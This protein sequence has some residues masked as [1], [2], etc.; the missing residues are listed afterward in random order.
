[1]NLSKNFTLRE[2]SYSQSAERRGIDNTPPPEVVENLKALCLAVLQPLREATG[3]I[4]VTS[5]Y[6]A[7]AL[8]KV[9]GGNAKGQHPLGQAADCECFAMSTRALAEKVIELKL[10]FDQLI[11]EFASDYDADAGWVHVSHKKEGGNR[12]QVLRAVRD[13]EGKTRYLPGL[14]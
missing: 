7:P 4:T 5:G 14:V 13:A 9:V 12:G 6:R 8:N 11:M 2:L 1:M 3:Q 10:P